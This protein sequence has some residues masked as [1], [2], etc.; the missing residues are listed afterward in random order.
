MKL[1]C[2]LCEGELD[3]VSEKGFR[4]KVK[5]KS[6]GFSSAEEKEVKMPEVIKLRK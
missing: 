3:I 2:L 6:C 5:C 4:K 1:N